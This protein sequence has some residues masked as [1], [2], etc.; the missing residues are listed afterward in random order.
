MNPI[1][2]PHNIIIPRS[3][4]SLV[5]IV[6]V[7]TFVV[8]YRAYVPKKIFVCTQSY[9]SD[10]IRSRI[11]M[12]AN[13]ERISK[14]ALSTLYQDIKR[15]VP[16]LNNIALSHDRPGR[17]SLHITTAIPCAVVNNE[18]V[19]TSQGSLVP[20]EDYAHSIISHLPHILIAEQFF[21]EKSR[22]ECCEWIQNVPLKI[23]ESFFIIW[24]A[25]SHIELL[26]RDENLAGLI[27]ITWCYTPF[28]PEML[29][30][31]ERVAQK[32]KRIDMR[33]PHYAIVSPILRGSL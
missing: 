26:P 27:F 24:Y 7:T 32:N 23:L 33:V 14:T 3:I 13:P 19:L 5:M 21:C 12:Y 22:L 18:Q 6:L 17:V 10:V 20:L 2:A 15:I 31:M 9:V 1:I 8:L 16:S 28:S 30:V 4:S 11:A 29:A 25:R